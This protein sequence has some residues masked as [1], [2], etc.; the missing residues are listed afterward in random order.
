MG[1]L[2]AF[3]AIAIAVGGFYV[4]WELIPPFFHNYELKDD[5]DDIARV[6][7]YTHKTDDDIKALVIKRASDMNISLKDE[8]VQVSRNV[9]G[10]G[11]SVHYQV[12][13]DLLVHPVDLDFTTESINK[14]AY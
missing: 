4:G 12:H 13:V 2:K 6:N 7:S 9:D 11:I 8:Q 10:M 5:L 3:I 14:R 1:K